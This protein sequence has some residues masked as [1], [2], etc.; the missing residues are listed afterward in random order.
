MFSVSLLETNAGEYIGAGKRSLK[1]SP[2]I[3]ESGINLLSLDNEYLGVDN[4]WY[5]A[6]VLLFLPSD[7]TQN[8]SRKNG[9]IRMMPA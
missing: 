1:E 5:P 6:G 4:T 2:E 8:L 9:L 7:M 3:V